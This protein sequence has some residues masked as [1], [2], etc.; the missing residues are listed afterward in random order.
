MEAFLRAQVRPSHRRAALGKAAFLEPD[1]AHDASFVTDAW[2]GL[3][4]LTALTWTTTL[5]P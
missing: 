2:R 3:A 1:D 5:L 4:T